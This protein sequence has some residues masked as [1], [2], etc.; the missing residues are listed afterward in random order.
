LNSR[1]FVPF[2]QPIVAV[3]TAGLVG[4]EILARWD[5]PEMGIIGPD[6]FIPLAEKDGW[7]RELT[8]II[9]RGAFVAAAEQLPAPLTISINVSPLELHHAEM[10]LQIRDLAEEAGFALRRT[11]IEITESALAENPKQAYATVSALKEWGCRISLDDFGTGYSSLLQLQSMP[12]DA[13]K[14]D[15]SF[16]SSMTERRDSRKIVAAVIGMGQSLGLTTVAEGVETQEQADMLLWLGCDQAQGW[17]YG[18]PAPARELAAIIAAPQARPAAASFRWK[19]LTAG[20]LEGLPAQ[21]LAQL[22]A[23]YDGAPVA[24]G[25]LDRGL[26][27]VN[28]NRR[29][30]DMHRKPLEEHYGRTISEVVMPDIYAQIAPL[31]DRALGGEAVADAEIKGYQPEET[32][33]ASYQP[34]R[35]EAGEVVGVSCAVTDFTARKRAE[36][37]LRQFERLVEGVGEMMAV[38]D[39]DYRYVLANRAYLRYR[40]MT[41][42]EFVGARVSDIAGG[43]LFDSVLKAHF[44]ECFQGKSVQF[45]VRHRYPELGERDL[46]VSLAPVEMGGGVTAAACIFRDVTDIKRLERAETGWRKRI[47]LAQEA[48]LRIGLWDWDIDANTV[49]WSEETYRQWGFTPETFSGRVEDA[50]TRL[51]PGDNA[52]VALAIARVLSGEEKEFAEQYRIVRP[53]GSTCWLDAHGVVLQDEGLHMMGVGVDITGLKTIQLSLAESEEKYLLLLNS[54]AEAIYGLDLNGL[55]TFCNPACLRF[56]GYE[57]PADLLGKDMHRLLHHTRPDGT[58][59]PAEDCVIYRAIREGM[60]THVA[61]DILWR[62]DGSRLDVECWSHPLFRNGEPVGAVVT[63]LDLTE[64]RRA[65]EARRASEAQYRELFENATHGIVVAAEDGTLLDANPAVIRMLGYDSKEELLG[66]N[67]QRDIEL[68]GTSETGARECEWM[69]KDGKTITVHLSSRPI[70]GPDGAVT[71]RQ[72]IAEDVTERRSLEEQFRHAQK[73]EAV[74][75]LA[76]GVAHDFN[77][78]LTI[79]NGYSEM[80]LHKLDRGDPDRHLVE[81]IKDAGWRSAALTKQLLVFSRKQI[82]RPRHTDLNQVIADF[83]V[84]LRRIIG[85]DIVLRSSLSPEPCPVLADPGRIEQVVMNLVVNARDAMPEGGEIDIETSHVFLD[86]AYAAAHVNVRRGDYVLLTVRD[87]GAGM[88][89]EVKNHLFEPFF[90]TKGPDKGTGLGLAVVHGI[91]RDGE[92]HIEVE[93]EPGRGTTFRIYLPMA[94]MLSGRS[95]PAAAEQASRGGA[96]TILLV[97]DDAAVRALTSHI[98]ST[99]GYFVLQVSDGVAGLRIAKSYTSRIDL[100]ATDIVMPGISGTQLALEMRGSHPE[101]RVLYLSGYS[102]TS[103]PRLGLDGRKEYLIEKPFEP[104]ALAEKIREVLDAA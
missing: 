78:L 37:R 99:R 95:A 26:K 50:V 31:L 54:T 82:A 103:F 76:G 98:L 91:V 3:R 81:Q 33:L 38:V 49:I 2:F 36:E 21:R 22:Q 16:V 71:Q 79:I 48:G 24:L 5:H 11:V 73:M 96:E 65:E 44:D 23:V 89:E 66:R 13:L 60:P 62:A 58:P 30:A 1:Q 87:T 84:M 18:R 52:R 34:A 20:N 8:S 6:V 74:G 32:F 41:E 28:L 47:E 59:Y 19:N 39:R 12:F 61:E 51:H 42:E 17:L 102:D 83:E 9:V 75:Q 14:V 88:S 43:E 104:E 10:A 15:R 35:D 27:Y 45:A 55:C 25:F 70:R 46:D 85:E 93:S 101:T 72:V 64:R 97:E 29:L 40:V 69:R 67:L 56:L 4:F 80:L 92:G 57:M 86:D 53:D 7:I 68:G 94:A 100:L 63:F 77:N 90:T